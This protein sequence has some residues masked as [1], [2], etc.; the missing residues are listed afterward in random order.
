MKFL[1]IFL[2]LL[3]FLLYHFYSDAP[4]SKSQ[5]YVCATWQ[6]WDIRGGNQ[7]KQKWNKNFYS[8]EIFIISYLIAEAGDFYCTGARHAFGRKKCVYS[9]IRQRTRLYSQK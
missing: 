4:R 7:D 3:N 1:I 5:L 8:N 6:E 9:I 2:Q